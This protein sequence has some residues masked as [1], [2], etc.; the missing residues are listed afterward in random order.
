VDHVVHTYQHH[1]GTSR[2][3]GYGMEAARA[4]GVEADRVFKTLVV[5]ASGRH[6]FG[7]VAVGD[8]LDLKLMARAL[9]EK[10]VSIASPSDAERVTG[11][12]VGAISPLGG[13][14]RLPVVVDEAA[15]AYDTI[16]V[17]AGL[18]GVEVELAP[19]ILLEVTDGHI[20]TIARRS[21]G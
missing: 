2:D 14:A 9:G 11:S 10:Q 6:V 21:Q 18:R 15:A 3:I 8:R 5:V 7:V 4:L 20:A 19:G 13:R 12:V 17:S 16:L 1:P